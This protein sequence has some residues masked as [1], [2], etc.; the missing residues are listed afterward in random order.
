MGD[1]RPVGVAS[2]AR[3]LGVDRAT[4]SRDVD[5]LLL[6][7]FGAGKAVGLGLRLRIS[8][9]FLRALFPTPAKQRIY[10]EPGLTFPSPRGGFETQRGCLR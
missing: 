1:C 9:R 10:E 6:E 3:A 7:L 8:C 4:V 2:T 5:A